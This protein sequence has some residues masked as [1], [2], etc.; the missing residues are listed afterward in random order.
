MCHPH[1]VGEASGPNGCWLWSEIVAT[2]VEVNYRA[3]QLGWL[4]DYRFHEFINLRDGSMVVNVFK[5]SNIFE[6]LVAS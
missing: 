2:S 1:P 4:L 6:E 5:W 3:G